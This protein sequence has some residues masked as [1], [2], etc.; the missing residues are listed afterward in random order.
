MMPRGAVLGM[1][2]PI[3]DGGH[4]IVLGGSDGHDFGRMKELGEKYR[5]PDDVMAYDFDSD[6][7]RGVGAMPLGVV[8]GAVIPIGSSNW[9]V[10]GGEHSPGLRT[11]WVQELRTHRA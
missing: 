6:T 11:P 8:G 4:A 10:V 2:I 7:W 9:L 3:E 1:G 5:I